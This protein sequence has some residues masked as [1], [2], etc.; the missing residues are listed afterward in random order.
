M[1]F[2]REVESRKELPVLLRDEVLWVVVVFEVV[3]G[4]GFEK[5]RTKPLEDMFECTKKIK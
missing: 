5:G 4:V 3:A 2:G 1:R